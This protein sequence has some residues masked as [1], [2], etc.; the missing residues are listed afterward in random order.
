MLIEIWSSE[1][2]VNFKKT[3]FVFG[4]VVK[5]KNSDVTANQKQNRTISNK[6]QVDKIHR[7]SRNICT[8]IVLFHHVKSTPL[9]YGFSCGKV[10]GKLQQL[11]S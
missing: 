11:V 7:I 8:W 10:V 9:V 5:A 1:I 6:T 4:I 3:L 2:N